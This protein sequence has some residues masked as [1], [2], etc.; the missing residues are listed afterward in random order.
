MVSIYGTTYITQNTMNVVMGSK[1]HITN[2]VYLQLKQ[3]WKAKI[4]E[5]K[6]W[7][8]VMVSPTWRQHHDFETLFVREARNLTQNL[9][10]KPK[11]SL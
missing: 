7:D 1:E 11:L 2:V 5:G 9:L 4:W 3:P 10:P 8:Y 6:I